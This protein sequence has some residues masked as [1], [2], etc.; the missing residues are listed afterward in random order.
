[1]YICLN[2]ADM[3]G[4]APLSFHEGSVIVISVTS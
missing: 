4:N 3:W 1:M 2:G